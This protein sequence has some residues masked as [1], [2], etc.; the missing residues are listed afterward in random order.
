MF[1]LKAKAFSNCFP[2][3]TGYIY[4]KIAL[5]QIY[6]KHK[7]CP[8][9]RAALVFPAMK[10]REFLAHHDTHADRHATIEVGHIFVTHAE[11]A[12]RHGLANCPWLIGAVDAV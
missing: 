5:F 3:L 2:A 11:T 12:R 10:R 7:G 1:V 8:D 4:I 6:E 9:K